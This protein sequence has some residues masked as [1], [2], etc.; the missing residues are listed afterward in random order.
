MV[1]ALSRFVLRFGLLPL[2]KLSGAAI[3]PVIFSVNRGWILK[4]WDHFLIPKP[5]SRIHARFGEP[6]PAIL[7]AEAFEAM[8]LSVER[9][10][11]EAQEQ[12]DQAQGWQMSLF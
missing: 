4:S 9:T 6:I 10:I 2:A 8:R 1:K 11:R 7:D 5:F 12:D 3:V